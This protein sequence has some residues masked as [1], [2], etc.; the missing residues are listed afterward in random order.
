MQAVADVSAML[1]IADAA[2]LD[3]LIQFES[4]WNPLARNPIS[5]ARGLI[6]FMPGTARNMGYASADALAESLPDAQQQ[7]RGPVQNYL[8]NYAPFPTKQSLYMSV[9]YPA[10]RFWPPSDMFSARVRR[11]NP[12]IVTVQDYI[13]KVD[14]VWYA[15]KAAL[16][17]LLAA[18]AAAWWY[19]H[20]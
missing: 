18:G 9:F 15:K 7:L 10:A 19:F 3:R 1:D 8:A 12:G 13:D 16:P 2:W 14:G 6:Q 17:L 11:Q 4:R 20:R 5:G